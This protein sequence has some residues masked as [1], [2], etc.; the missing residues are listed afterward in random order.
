MLA[1]FVI[2]SVESFIGQGIIVMRHVHA[3]HT[4]IGK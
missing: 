3:H 2:G 4:M 1:L